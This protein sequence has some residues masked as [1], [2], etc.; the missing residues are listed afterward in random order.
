MSGF[1]DRKDAFENKYAHDEKLNFDTE[2][3]C[4]KIFGLWAATQLG[5]SGPDAETYAKEVVIANLD[6]PGFDDVFR[7]VR[8]DF[9]DKGV[10]VSDH[11]MHVEMD[12]ALAEAKKQLAAK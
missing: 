10:D 3:K 5:I 6:E 4:C 2:A 7:K 11:V 12:K 9:E 1:D 8:A